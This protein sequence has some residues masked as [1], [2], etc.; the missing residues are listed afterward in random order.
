MRIVYLGTPTDAVP[1][2]T[3]LHNAGHDVV[4]VVT[5]PDRRRGRGRGLDPSP[6]KVEAERLGIEVQTPDDPSTLLPW[7]S[8][9]GA[10][11]GVVVAYG[12][13]LSAEFLTSTPFGFLNIHYSL[14]PR[15]RGAAPVERA[16]LAGDATTGVCVMQLEVGLDTGP[17]WARSILPISDVVTA[18][19]LRQELT[20]VGANL[21]VAT[22]PDIEGG[23]RTP[24][25]QT[26]T[27]TYAS[28]LSVEE[29]QVDFT[30]PAER[31]ALVIRAGNPKPGAW[32][33]WRGSRIKILRATP[34]NAMPAPGTS[35]SPAHD[36]LPAAVSRETSV[37]TAE[38]AAPGTVL[39]VTADGVR[40]ALGDGSMI[41]LV[42]LQPA[43][44]AAMPASAWASGAQPIGSVFGE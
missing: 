5:Q 32:T 18:G 15:W 17:V 11:I 2:L 38:S 29:F 1:P 28:K 34:A 24:E 43:G 23:R 7:L 40:V 14:L 37:P 4:G 8:D 10:E 44:K 31:A 39:A 26:G 20:L 27:P 3:A 19:G 22:L 12:K 42:E 36:T 35:T 16:M 13:I 30:M 21:L 6:V 41:D 9:L 25:A 33:M